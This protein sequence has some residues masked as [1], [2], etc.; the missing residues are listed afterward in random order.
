MLAP[1]KSLHENQ[2]TQDRK[3]IEEAFYAGIDRYFDLIVKSIE[4]TEQEG[5]FAFTVKMK[6][7]PEG[8]L[9]IT[10]KFKPNLPALVNEREGEIVNGQ[11]RMF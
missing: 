8:N 11:L 5:G 10:D 1:V 3:Q 7:D 2:T 4:E 9:G 6:H